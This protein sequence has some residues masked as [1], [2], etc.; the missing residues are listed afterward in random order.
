MDRIALPRFR[1]PLAALLLGVAALLTTV[2]ASGSV[3]E[4]VVAIVGEKAI[5]LSDLR[6]R[7]KPF[8][9]R[10][11]KQVPPGAQR[12][13]AISQVFRDVLGR[14]IDEYLEQ[15]AANQSRIV[16]TSQEVDSAIGRI[17]DQ[18]GI[19]VEEL[20]GEAVLSGMTEEEY[21]KEIRRQ[22]LD[23]KL[24]NLRLQGRIRV[25]EDDLKAEYRSI[26]K[27]ERQRLGFR[28]AWITLALPETA[29]STQTAQVRALADR[30]ARQARAGSDF[31]TL[32][33]EHSTD[34]STRDVGGL[35]PRMKPGQLPPALDRVVAG[36][37]VG[38]VSAPVRVGEQLYVVSLIERDESQLPSYEE[39]QMELQNRVYLQKMDQARRRW[40]DQLRNRTH[41][42]IRL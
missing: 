29:N 17:A 4:R 33:R 21:R 13:A 37:E 31:A 27:S 34:A 26:V 3:V 19:A 32:A 8:L 22:V 12:N 25:T 14:M 42:E 20:V 5:L 16:V 7:S 6:A 28:V 41:V 9:V 39:A 1:A 11:H 40:L 36:L 10:I 18:N 2:A 38:E 30:I 35:L 15:R 24:M 23:A